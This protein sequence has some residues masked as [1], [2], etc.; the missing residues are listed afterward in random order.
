MNFLKRMNFEETRRRHRENIGAI[1]FMAIL[2]AITLALMVLVSA[3]IDNRVQQASREAAQQERA[4][5]VRWITACE[6]QGIPCSIQGTNM[7]VVVVKK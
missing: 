7:W 4:E 6:K 1:L 5:F 2:S 3:D